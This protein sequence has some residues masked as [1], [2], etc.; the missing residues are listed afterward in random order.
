VQKTLRNTSARRTSGLYRFET[1]ALGNPAAHLKNNLAE[2]DSHRHFN[3]TGILDGSGEREH[4][5]AFAA[6]GS[7]PRKPRASIAHNRRDIRVGF[8]VVDER[9]PAPQSG[10]GGIR[11]TRPRGSP[12]PF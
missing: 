11:R 2:G 8:Y 1:A 4:F 7:N 3:E 5:R 10:F 6:F 12:L 9:G